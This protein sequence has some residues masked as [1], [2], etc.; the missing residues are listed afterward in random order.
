R[1]AYK[2]ASQSTLLEETSRLWGEIL[3]AV[4]S[5]IGSQQTFDTWFK[6]IQPIR[7]GPHAVELEV[8][9]S[10]FVD[11]I[12]QHHLPTL[13]WGVSE[14]LGHDLEIRFATR[15]ASDSG[16]PPIPRSSE[17]GHV[18]VRRG[19]GRQHQGPLHPR[20][21]FPNFVVGSSNQFTHAACR[22]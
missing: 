10:F 8:P 19:S 9:N 12:H 14:V 4:Q 1:I 11:W 3:A 6:P 22:A 5:R 13:H 18:P 7:L 17:N 20:Y 2:M 15:E 16:P 21:T